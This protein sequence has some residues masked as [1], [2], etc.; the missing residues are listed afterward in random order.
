M[1]IQ[2]IE[3][4]SCDGKA[5]KKDLAE[6]KLDGHRGLLHFGSEL[7]RPHLTGRRLS[8]KTGLLTEKAENVPHLC[9]AVA[10][11]A[12][13][14]KLGYTVL[15]GEVLVKG[16]NFESVQSV[17]GALAPKAIEWQRA[18][19]WMSYAVFDVLFYDGE[20]V[21]Q[22]PLVERVNL[23]IQIL[24]GLEPFADEFTKPQRLWF[25]RDGQVEEFFAEIVSA[26]G[27]GLVLKD[28]KA[29]YGR[30]WTK[31]KKE[32]TYDVVVRGFTPG[33]GKYVGLIGAIEFGIFR[34]GLIQ[35]LGRCSGM[36]DPQ[37]RMF[38][39]Q[40]KQL[41]G[42]VMEVECSG[43]TAHGRLRHPRFV[44]LRPDKPAE[45]CKALKI[46]EETHG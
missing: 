26:G 25:P 21:R 6:E 39:E 20:D 14:K 22:I 2:Q 10:E 8:V 31:L 36:T 32:Q 9:D 42:S 46:Q 40:Q 44:R 28:M 18:N 35:P 12:K 34:D 3:P 38:T 41:V 7:G 29:A 23:T 45:Q 11:F 37:R 4:A 17:M 27:E 43:V 1:D 5:T 19:G 30:G 16:Q 13:L 24:E 15:D 33:Q